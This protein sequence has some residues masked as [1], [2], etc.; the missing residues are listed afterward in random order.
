[1][2]ERAFGPPSHDIDSVTDVHDLVVEFYREVVF[3]D[4]LEPVF[5]EVAEVDWAEHI[6][7]LIDYW[8]RILLD[9]PGAP[10]PV[11]QVH[12]DLHTK[13]SITP[14]LCDRWFTLWSECV[15]Q[16]WAGPVADRAVSHAASLMS[17]MAKHLFGCVWER[18]AVASHDP[19]RS[20]VV[21]PAALGTR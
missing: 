11:M 7:K 5:G 2:R 4:L 6:P 16:R 18:P 20:G 3:D 1:M 8:S 15:A 12:R 10:G 19:G 14:D 9:I 13:S 21:A 17:G